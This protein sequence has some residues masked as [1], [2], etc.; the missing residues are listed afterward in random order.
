M[1]QG[2]LIFLLLALCFKDGLYDYLIIQTIAL[3]GIFYY[4]F[5]ILALYIKMRRRIIKPTLNMQMRKKAQIMISA[6]VLATQ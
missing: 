5:C 1:F 4:G 6:I 2:L 3:G